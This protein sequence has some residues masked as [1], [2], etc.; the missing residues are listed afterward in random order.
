MPVDNS[1]AR[2][3]TD[4]SLWILGFVVL[5]SA[6][7]FTVFYLYDRYV[8]PDLTVLEYQMQ[9]VQD[10]VR[11]NPQN[12]ELRV[13]AARQ[14]LD[15]GMIEPAIQQAQQALVVDPNHQGALIVL[16]S[17]HKKQ[18][19]LDSAIMELNRVA[20]LNRDNPLARI[21]P[22]IEAVYYELGMLYSEQG[23]YLDAATTFKEALAIDATDADA[24][25]ALGIVYQKQSDHANAVLEFLQAVRFIPDFREAYQGLA[26]SS[27]ALGQTAQLAYAQAM[28]SLYGGQPD[29][30]AAALEQVIAQAPDLQTA[31]LGLGLAYEKTGKPER[32][33]PALQM[34]LTSHPDD[35][36]ANQALGRLTK[37][38]GQ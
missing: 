17:A 30:A 3:S 32:G 14:F 29:A 10:L 16:A 19:D 15:A 6:G 34:Y 8:H 23:K 37:G 4:W 24:H 20:T 38:K 33:I 2:R 18:G 12:S 21:D 22:R 9:T 1:R 31:Y 36:A 25:Y 13:A 35:I 26:D 7:S 11:Q 27:S 5:L 28:V